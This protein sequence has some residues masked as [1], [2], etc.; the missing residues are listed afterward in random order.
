MN[1]LAI[2]FGTKRI[3][4]AYS[5]DGIIST[6]PAIKNDPELIKNIKKVINEYHID[7]IYV[8]ISEGVFG[9]T[10]QKFVTYLGSMIR[11]PIDTVEEAVST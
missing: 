6:L 1:Y 7:K 4:L 8:G 9:E 5:Q 11:L 3:G 2:D 10:T